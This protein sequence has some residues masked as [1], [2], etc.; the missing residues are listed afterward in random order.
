V[1]LNLMKTDVIGQQ[2]AWTIPKSII[3]SAGFWCVGGG[4]FMV[5]S[6]WYFHVVKSALVEPLEV[7]TDPRKFH[8]A[9]RAI[10]QFP[11]LNQK[12]G[13]EGRR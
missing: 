8:G 3:R 9:S 10:S 5:F 6:L 4:V 11:K 2:V 12:S 7:A 1:A 13:E